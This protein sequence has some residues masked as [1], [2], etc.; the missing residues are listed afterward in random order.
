MQAFFKQSTRVAPP[1]SIEHLNIANWF[2][3]LNKKRQQDIYSSVTNLARLNA[4]AFSPFAYGTFTKSYS[5][6][7]VAQHFLLVGNFILD[8]HPKFLLICCV[9]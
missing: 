7:E 3:F 5:L 2:G 6:D 4:G 9:P 8:F 1:K